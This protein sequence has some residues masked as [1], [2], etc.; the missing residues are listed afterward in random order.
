[1][2]TL[3]ADAKLVLK[4]THTATA[5]STDL[6][7]STG[8]SAYVEKIIEIALADGTGIGKVNQMFSDRRTINASSSEDL[9]LAGGVTDFTGS[10]FTFSKVKLIFISAATT[11]TNNVLVGDSASNPWSALFGAD[12][13]TTFKPGFGLCA[14]ANPATDS[15][16]TVTNN[17]SDILLVA[18]SSSGSSV[19]YD[20][21]IIGAS[22]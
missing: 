1:M 20:I 17:S 6:A 22:A 21:V 13:V 10:T 11:N 12:G 3:T 2:A 8:A 15:G 9:D 18:N 16:W 4:A 19:T 5:A 14:W 7:V